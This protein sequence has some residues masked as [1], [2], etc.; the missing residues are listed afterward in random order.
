MLSHD[1]LTGNPVTFSPSS[2]AAS[3][4][5]APFI[6]RRASGAHGPFIVGLA[7]AQGSGKSTVARQVS[8]A[9][10]AEGLRCGVVSLDD[11]YLMKAER[12]RLAAR[13]HPLLATRGPPGTHDVPLG[14]DLF[15]R[16]RQRNPTTCPTFDKI[17]DDRAPPAAWRSIPGQLDVVLFEGWC[18]GARAEPSERLARPIN[19]LEREHDADGRWRAWVNQQL[20]EHYPALF[21]RLDALVFLRAP[22][23]DVVARWRLQ[24]E[25]ANLAASGGGVG[26]DEE[27]V[28]RFIQHYERLT[29]WMLEEL[30]A[31]ADLT[32]ELD[33]VRSVRVVDERAFPAAVPGLG[34]PI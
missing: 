22:S 20:A 34:N 28:R 11:L 21:A 1:A 5:I 32:L 29:R 4:A 30:P 3:D 25:A 14:L 23:F 6:R 16:L 8:K 10:D 7:G 2:I 19:A 9:L 27:Q 13:I 33:E 31:R 12:A 18:V 24:Q 26:M 15:S 17:A